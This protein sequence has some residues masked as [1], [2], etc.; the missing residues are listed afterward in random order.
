MNDIQFVFIATVVVIILGIL[1]L[2]LIEILIKTP[3]K[4]KDRGGKKSGRS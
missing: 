4:R 3:S 1:S 2:S